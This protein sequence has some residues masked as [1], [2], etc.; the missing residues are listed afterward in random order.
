M[1]FHF[2]KDARGKS[3]NN[4]AFDI[5]DPANWQLIGYDADEISISRPGGTGP[6]IVTFDLGT[7]DA[8]HS[9]I[10]LIGSSYTDVLVR[11]EYTVKGWIADASDY[12]TGGPALRLSGTNG[13]TN[14]WYGYWGAIRKFSSRRFIPRKVIA[15]VSNNFGVETTVTSAWSD[16]STHILAE[17]EAVGTNI[18]TRAKIFGDASWAHN[19]TAVDAGA[20]GPG[21]V[22]MF[23]TKLYVGMSVEIYD[24]EVI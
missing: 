22:G 23:F 24:F 2:Q 17:T 3:A 8:A 9:G 19:D 7:G 21:M 6:L 5:L 11:A 1:S 18:S 20:A 14:T 16:N 12:V 15:G 4:V 10:G 13:V